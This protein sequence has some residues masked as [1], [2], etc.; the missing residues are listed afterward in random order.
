MEYYATMK[1]DELQQKAS[2]YTNCK[3]CIAETQPSLH[4]CFLLVP[5]QHWEIHILNQILQSTEV[6]LSNGTYN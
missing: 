2:I 6:N 4:I 3:Y 1:T 5:R